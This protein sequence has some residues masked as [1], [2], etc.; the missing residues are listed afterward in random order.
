MIR[1]SATDEGNTLCFKVEGRLAG[2][3]VDELRGAILRRDLQCKFEVDLAE[4]TFV[5]EDGE[6]LLVWIDRI[7]GR[8]RNPGVSSDYLLERLGIATRARERS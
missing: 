4:V 5:D 6:T 8:L 2:Y 1:I 3:G 7:G